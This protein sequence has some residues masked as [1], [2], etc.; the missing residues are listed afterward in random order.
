MAI[1]VCS[2][3]GEEAFLSGSKKSRWLIN[4]VL[5]PTAAARWTQ[6]DP[7]Q[8]TRTWNKWTG[9]NRQIDRLTARHTKAWPD[10]CRWLKRQPDRFGWATSRQTGGHTEAA[11]MEI[12]PTCQPWNILIIWRPITL[13]PDRAEQKLTLHFPG[14]RRWPCRLDLHCLSSLYLSTQLA[15]LPSDMGEKAMK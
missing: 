2:P 6:T 9:V 3:S 7:H 11:C 1:L 13:E 14:T 8:H 15:L 10:T 4:Y 12:A 5:S